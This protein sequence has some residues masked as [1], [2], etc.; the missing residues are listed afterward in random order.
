MA[1]VTITIPDE[2]LDRVLAGL[3]AAGGFVQINQDNALHVVRNFIK[4]TVTNIEN[5]A[6]K[7]AALAAVDSSAPIALS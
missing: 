7:A 1:E 6:A 4:Q 5:T 3:C 2:D